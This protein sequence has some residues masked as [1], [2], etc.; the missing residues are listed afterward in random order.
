MVITEDYVLHAESVAYLDSLRAL[1]RSVNTE[2]TYAGR[3]ALYL[4]Y[5]AEYGIDWAAPRVRQLQELMRWLVEHPLPPKGRRPPV[6]P[7]FRSEGSANAVLTTV[8]E[9]LRFGTANGWVAPEITAQLSEPKYLHHLPRGFDPGEDDQFRT[10][11]A[12]RIKYQL[13]VE[14]YEWLTDEQID[15]LI[16]LTPRA[17]DRFLVTLLAC[18]GMRIGEGLGI[19]RQD[20]HLLSDSSSL[21]CRT[22]GPHVHVRRRRNANGALAKARMPRSIPVTEELVGSYTDYLIERDRVPEAAGIDFVF[23]NL[24]HDPLGQPLRYGNA[25]EMF[26]RLAKKAGFAARPHMLRHSAA[27]RWVRSGTARDVVQD[28]LGHVSPSSMQPYLHATDQDK[29]EAVERVEAARKGRS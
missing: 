26:D 22:A 21:G 23:V 6:E 24:F 15:H 16:D 7:R 14:G 10:V 4:S 1:D 11:R 18:T 19:R 12:R 28:L 27:T 29:R 2:R 3:I 9:F 8:C 20:V 13:A 25:K 17:R 5:C